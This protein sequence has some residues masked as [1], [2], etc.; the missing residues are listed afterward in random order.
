MTRDDVMREIVDHVNKVG[1]FMCA[2]SNELMQRA[3]KHDRS[4]FDA[5]EFDAFVEAT[6]KLK[7][8]TY[9]S[10]EYKANIE[11]IRPAVERHYKLNRH[12]PEYF[13]CLCGGMTLIDLMEMLCDWKAAT[14]RHDDGDLR[15]SIAQNKERF[16]MSDQLEM[17]LLKTAESMGWC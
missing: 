15:R 16:S 6:P 12:H 7:G 8:L 1:E 3:V 2:V 11:S 10:D 9:G 5:E 4:K 14:L 13:D 17:I